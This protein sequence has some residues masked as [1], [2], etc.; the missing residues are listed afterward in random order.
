MEQIEYVGKKIWNRDHTESGTVTNKSSRYCAV[1]GHT[2][3][4][5]VLWNNNKKTKPCL[6]GIKILPNKELQIM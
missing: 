1:C 6:G 4:L 2:S 5:I 3:C